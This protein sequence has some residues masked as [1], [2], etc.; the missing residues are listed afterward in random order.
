VQPRIKSSR[1]TESLH[2]NS[3]QIA[4]EHLLRP[5]LSK[6]LGRPTLASVMN[7]VVQTMTALARRSN[8]GRNSKINLFTEM[9]STQMTYSGCF[10]KI[11]VI[12]MTYLAEYSCKWDSNNNRG[13]ATDA[14]IISTSNR[15]SEVIHEP[16]LSERPE[17][18]SLFQHHSA[19]EVSGNRDKEELNSTN[20]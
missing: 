16:K 4:T 14:R 10:S 6:N 9:T 17:E 2:L 1:L 19:Q 5:R 7:P 3:T 20:K 12:S 11:K 13:E 15:C 8:T 18:D